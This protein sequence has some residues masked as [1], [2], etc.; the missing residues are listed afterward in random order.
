M[1]IFAKKAPAPTETKSSTPVDF[2]LD[3][4]PTSPGRAGAAA[5]AAPAPAYG[6]AD[7]I[8]LMR[9][10]PTDGN[11]DL[12]VRV[13]R[14]TLGSVNVKLEDI[15]EDA[16]RRQK[17]IQDRIAGLH[18]QVADLEEQMEARRREISAQEA[19]LKETSAVKER[20]V[21]A[22]KAATSAGAATAVSPPPPPPP[23]SSRM[24]NLPRAT[25]ER[26]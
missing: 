16:G 20:L 26:E 2:E 12:V 14:V 10:L 7:A 25:P 6:I 22:E 13:V 24:A 15:I 21:L 3:V 17:A 18:A 5:P 19:D 4:D 23:P 11:M 9:S 1:A 8:Q